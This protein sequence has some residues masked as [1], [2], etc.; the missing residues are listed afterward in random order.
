MPNKSLLT[1]LSKTNQAGLTYWSPSS[2]I[3]NFNTKLTEM[4]GFLSGV[5]PWEDDANPPIPTQDQK[6]LKKTLKNVFVVKKITT[7]DI[8]PVIERIDWTN[9]T[10]YEYYR[11]DT[12]LSELNEN[13][14]LI[15]KFYVMN[16]YYQVFKCLWNNNYSPSTVEPY[17]EPGTYGTN[18]IFKGSDG[19][20]WKFMFNVDTTL[21]TRFMDDNWIPL[22]PK[23]NYPSALDNKYG[24]GSIDVINVLNGG[25]GYDTANS[26]VF[27]VISGD[28]VASNGTVFTTAT[29]TAT[30]EDG[31]ITDIIVT[32][33]G[34]NYTYANAD[35]VSG[36]GSGCILGAN[37]VSPIGGHGSDSASELACQHV[38]IS[39]QFDGSEGGNIPTDILY[40][41]LGLLVKPTAQST[42]P[43]SANSP[44]YKTTTDINVSPGLGAFLNNEIVWQG[45]SADYIDAIGTATFVGKVL[46]FD[47]DTN[48]IYLI[49]TK[50]TPTI[51]QTL[52]GQ[53]GTARTLLTINNPDYVLESGY[54]TYIE[55][56][57]GI[58][59]S[60]DGIEQFR[61]VLGY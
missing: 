4:Y 16:R 11:D 33:P 20:K 40:Y 7:R 25:S 14:N 18:K 29:A 54:I 21:R 55:N 8:S 1:T 17:F 43:E 51:N 22:T 56:R 41:Q 12:D 45:K 46:S 9:G 3:T 19:Y 6:S 49:N 59:R 52:Y 5:D 44:I 35:I 15:N 38:M 60:S 23:I 42:Y 47:P 28:G 13:G 26:P 24:S 27:V 48:T 58:Q 10:T 57:S 30:V 2:T 37:T 34:K 39:V 36:S 50:G 32:D 31:Q 53:S 61:I